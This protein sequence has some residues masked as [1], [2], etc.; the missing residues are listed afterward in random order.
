MKKATQKATPTP[1]EETTLFGPIPL[2]PAKAM[3]LF[4]G[5][6]AEIELKNILGE[7]EGSAT[8]AVEGFDASTS[9]GRDR[10]KS[11]AYKVARTKTALDDHGKELVADLKDKAGRIDRL[12]KV[13]RDFLDD[14]KERVRK[15]LTDYENRE[16]ERVAALERRLT[17]LHLFAEIP[18]GAEIPDLEKQLESIREIDPT[19]FEEFAGRARE[20][21][22]M[23]WQKVHAR[24]LEQRAAQEQQLEIA[25]LK[26]ESEERDRELALLRAKVQEQAAPEPPAQ[27]AQ[28]NQLPPPESAPQNGNNST[29]APTQDEDERVQRETNCNA[30]IDLIKAVPDLTEDQAKRVL[31]AIIRREVSGVFI[32]YQQ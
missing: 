19:S 1:T 9:E 29:G 17:E 7:V 14:L 26:K 10:L 5:A 4:Q 30:L 28:V 8:N 24:L 13:A 16:K 31:I 21:Q 20:I 11:V 6:K 25:R 23:A 22:A 2:T 27:A 12:R 15:P 3:T 18:V 32:S